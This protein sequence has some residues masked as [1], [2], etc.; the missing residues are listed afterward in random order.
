MEK[1]LRTLPKG[2]W[3]HFGGLSPDTTPEDIAAFLYGRG[4]DVTAENVSV[5]RYSN[6]PG[7]HAMV[8]IPD[9][10]FVALVNWAIDGEKLNGREV[11]GTV[12]NPASAK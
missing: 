9:L 6:K 1:D 8:S 10:V 7:C 5:K 11:V 3:F 4:I 12:F 2:K